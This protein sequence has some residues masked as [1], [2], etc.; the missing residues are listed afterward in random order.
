M[1]DDWISELTNIF[2]RHVPLEDERFI[3]FQPIESGE[4]SFKG[5]ADGIAILLDERQKAIS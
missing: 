3:S 2:K 1:W 5:E 4:E